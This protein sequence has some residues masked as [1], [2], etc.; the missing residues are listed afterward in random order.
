MSGA[1]P[2]TGSNSEGNSCSGLMF[3]DGAIPMGPVHAGPRSERMSPNRLD[4]TTTSNQSGCIT[5]CADRMSI[6]YW[7]GLT[8]GYRAPVNFEGPVQD[9]AGVQITLGL[10]A[11]VAGLA[12][13]EPAREPRLQ[14]DR[15]Q[16]YVLLEIAA[17]RDQQPPQGNVVGDRGRPA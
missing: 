4:P 1:D 8:S 15:A 10:V 11:E 14:P 6:W 13:V 5:K 7:L 12:A 9:G 2:C 16:I 17:K 3:A